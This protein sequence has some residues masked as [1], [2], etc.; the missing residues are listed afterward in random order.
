VFQ[1]ITSQLG[2]TLMINPRDVSWV[3]Y[4]NDGDLDLHVVDMGTSEQPNA[5]DRLWRND[6]ATFADVTTLENIAGGTEGMGDGGIWGDVDGD[7][8][9]D[10]VLREG[11]GPASFS[12]FAPAHFLLNEG[13]RGNALILNI[14]GR[15]SGAPAVGVK[16]TVV[17]G[18][19]R[20]VRRVQANSW[21]G[22]QDPLWI[23]AGLGE[24]TTADSVIVNWHTGQTQVYLGVPAGLWRFEEG[25]VI[26][27]AG[28]LGPAATEG[29]QLGGIAPQPA[30]DV[31]R[32]QFSARA[33]VSVTVAVHDLA[34]RTVRTLHRG[35]VSAGS[36]TFV[37]DGR[38]H[39]GRAVAAGIYWIRATDGAV[40]R[41]VKSVRVR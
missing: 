29:W 23:H 21:R 39:Q 20:I 32:V 15:Q 3:D 18:P 22:H 40:T 38:D 36:S 25:T 24:A 6:G 1:E 14:V 27:G 2:L 37:W 5:P 26:T 28:E 4:D 34:G 41:S 19:K 17:A 8:D 30:H 11:A 13:E 7:L 33:Q 16:V 31:Q 9:L 35:P 10:L 12:A